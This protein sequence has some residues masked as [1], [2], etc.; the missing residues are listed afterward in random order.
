MGTIVRFDGINGCIKTD[1]ALTISFD[2]RRLAPRDYLAVGDRVGVWIHRQKGVYCV[3]CVAASGK[4]A[5]FL[6]A[7]TLFL[8]GLLV[9]FAPWAAFS[10]Y[11]MLTAPNQVIYGT[12]VDAHLEGTL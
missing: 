7:C 9:I 11:E 1:N 3:L 5:H 4:M 6:A 12:Y 10:L 8:A 2:Q